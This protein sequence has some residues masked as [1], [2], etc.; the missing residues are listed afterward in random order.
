MGQLGELE[1]V[2]EDSGVGGL[3]GGGWSIGGLIGEGGRKV[4]KAR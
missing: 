4:V 2:E 3:A 1:C